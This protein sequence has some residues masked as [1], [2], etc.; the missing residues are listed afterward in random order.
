[1]MGARHEQTDQVAALR[2]IMARLCSADLTLAEAN[3]LRQEVSR[4]L[5]LR[6]VEAALAPGAP[7]LT[8][9]SMRAAS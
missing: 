7:T 2:G 9:L 1:M 6:N 5:E 3:A 4:L 8:L